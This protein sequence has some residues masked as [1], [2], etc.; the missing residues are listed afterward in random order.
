[1]RWVW[2][3]TFRRKKPRF[4]N[5]FPSALYLSISVNLEIN[6]LLYQVDDI[7]CN[8]FFSIFELNRTPAT[9]PC[10]EVFDP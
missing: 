3:E 8:P 6:N 2:N 1:M 5:I 7:F 9:M 10:W 4:L